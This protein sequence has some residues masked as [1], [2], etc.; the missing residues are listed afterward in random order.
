[1]PTRPLLLLSTALL[2]LAT[3]CTLGPDPFEAEPVATTQVAV[4]DNVYEP[5]AIQVAPGDEVTW[6]WE[7]RIEHNV[8][9]PGFETE[10]ITE[11]EFTHAFDEV[12]VVEYVCTIHPGMRGVVR[13]VDDA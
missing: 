4:R 5:L 3:G 13:V 7:G 11:G 9:G 10:L 2:V 6:T 1:M 8:V 12:G